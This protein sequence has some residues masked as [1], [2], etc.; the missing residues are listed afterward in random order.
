MIAIGGSKLSDTVLINSLFVNGWYR[1]LGQRQTWKK[2]KM[3]LANI[4]CVCIWRF[5]LCWY[6]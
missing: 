1:I 3:V 2:F 4:G 6:F 5:K